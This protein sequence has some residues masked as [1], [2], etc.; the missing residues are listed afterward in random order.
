METAKVRL[1]PLRF[2]FLVEQRDKNNLQRVF[3]M[4]SALWGGAFNFI[5][6]LFR[7]VPA[8]YRER[9]QKPISAKATLH[10]F[11]EAFQPDF[12]IETK[13]GQAA[14]CGIDFPKKRTRSISELLERDEED[15]CK[16][17]IDLRSVCDDLYAETFQFVQR[18]P[19]RVLLPSCTDKRFSLLFSAMF[20]SLPEKDSLSDIATI[21][22]E[23][24]G[25]EP[26]SFAAV[27]FPKVF[28]QRNL[29]PLRITRHKLSTHSI[30]S[31]RDGHFFYMD[32][33]SPLDLIEYWN[34]RA[35]GWKI[36]PLPVSLAPL[37]ASFCEDVMASNHQPSSSR[38]WQ[39][40]SYLCAYDQSPEAV[41][42]FLGTLKIPEGHFVSTNPH[43]PRIWEEWGR[44]ADQARPQIVTH[45][46]RSTDA[47]EIGNGLHVEAL[48]HEFAEDDQ[49][50]S[51][52]IASA[53]VVE[54]LS[55]TSPVIPWNRDVA[56]KLTYN[57][58]EEKTWL[59]REGI[60]FFAGD[61]VRSIYTR[62]PSSINIFKALAE[63]SGFELSL[64]PAGRTCEQIISALGS[65]GSIGLV[66]RSKE[67]LDFL[68]SLAHEDLE[69][70]L[71]EYDEQ[72]E[73]RPRHKK[74]RK[75]FA[76]YNETYSVMRKSNPGNETVAEPHLGALIRTK[77]LK[78]G[79]KLKC[80]ECLET[81]WFSL[82]DLAPMLPCPHCFSTFPFP[83]EVPPDRK[84]WAYR[85]IG[86]F[87]TYGYAKGSYCVAM[88]L[89]FISEKIAFKKSWIPSFHMM[90]DGKQEFEADFGMFVEPGATS[91]ISTPYLILGECK[92]Y[93]RFEEKDFARARKAAQLFPGAVL[94]FCTL[95]EALETDEIKGITKI[96]TA[97]RGRLDV[98]KQVNPVLILTATELF[99]QF[100][101]KEFALLYKDEAERV[102]RMIWRSEINEICEFTQKRYLGMP[103][104]HEVR[105]EKYKKRV[106]RK[107]VRSA[108]TSG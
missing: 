51:R 58:G 72:D 78:M 56:A 90:K 92:S 105:Q 62:L 100:N 94:C 96:V 80:T 74:P 106:A 103:S 30:N 46:S 24:L 87:A 9:Y 61:Y 36:L 13:P 104:S 29:F 27:D 54:S 57:F 2:A 21:Y 28:E 23:A 97:G 5:I 32:E 41:Q 17:G 38:A 47:R 81:R 12:I 33:T 69:V 98:G 85:V 50:C 53:N 55:G 70:D 77:V 4:N 48:P 7:S 45:A 49:F 89:Q 66:A 91:H 86:P 44:S 10:G 107:A 16:I 101:I 52:N 71:E 65:L 15:R 14:A 40:T 26:E 20:G 63:T 22:R 64:S 35:L 42:A 34:Y 31:L 84:D 18:H 3:E 25:G 37:L 1:R 73:E 79:M 6:P 82:E 76:P 39:S 68:N 59:S 83:T 19:Q 99:G 67:L 75:A 43:V 93:D 88:A 102:N 95:K 108:K 11:V 8:R 60:T